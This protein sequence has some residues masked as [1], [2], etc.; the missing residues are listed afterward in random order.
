MTAPNP[1]EKTYIEPPVPASKE[2]HCIGGILATIYG[3]GELQS[4]VHNVACLWLLHP[5]LQKQ[6]CM[7]PVACSTIHEW[8]KTLSKLKKSNK[9]TGLIAVSF[10]QRNHGTREVDP[11]A[12]EAW[13]SG[14][15]RHAQDMFASY[16]GTAMDTS[17]LIT[18]ISS[19]IFPSSDHSIVN[20]MVLGVSLG[21]HAAW[22]CLTQDSRV[23]TAIVI[24]GCPDYVRLISDRARLSKLETWTNSEPPGAYFLGSKDFPNG[25]IDALETYDPAGMLLGVRG[26]DES[27]YDRKPTEIELKR[28]TPLMEKSFKGKRL[29][30][31]SGGADKLVPY[32]CGEPFLRWLK[33]STAMNGWYGN[34]NVVVEDIVFEGVGHEMSSGMV[35]AVHRFLLESSDCFSPGSPS[36][37]SKI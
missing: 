33:S 16:H 4:D 36:R 26:R 30:N 20:N 2:T 34:A 13:K 37:V 1:M 25:L 18:Y 21:G 22:H 27:L 6:E 5:R 32:H 15:E 8:N 19:Y 12:N 14:N 29:L 10:D 17:H 35:E 24:I 9:T 28:L 31:M 23:T 7:E 11:V 3:L